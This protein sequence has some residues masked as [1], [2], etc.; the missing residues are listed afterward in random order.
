M[1]W[2]IELQIL[3]AVTNACAF[4]SARSSRRPTGFRLAVPPRECSQQDGK[5]EACLSHPMAGHG[6]LA[7]ILSRR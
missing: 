5:T 1:N 4:V 3:P 6:S 7:F 2:I